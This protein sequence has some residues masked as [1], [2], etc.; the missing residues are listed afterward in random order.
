MAQLIP[1]CISHQSAAAEEEIS[2]HAW[3]IFLAFQCGKWQFTFQM[4][5]EFI[6]ITPVWKSLDLLRP[7]GDLGSW[8]LVGIV[9]PVRGGLN[10]KN[11]AFICDI[12]PFERSLVFSGQKNNTASVKYKYH[13]IS[14]HINTWRRWYH[15][16]LL[17]YIT[18][19]IT[20]YYSNITVWIAITALLLG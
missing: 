5:S 12:I 11:S 17:S 4:C 1:E 13:H 7:A 3:L 6:Q 2:S 19:F 16:H 8:A 14:I 18:V 9:I 10:D 20:V 15:E